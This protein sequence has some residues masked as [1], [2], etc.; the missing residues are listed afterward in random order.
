MQDDKTLIEGAEMLKY[1]VET[2]TLKT[3]T[4]EKTA[5]M[6]LRESEI[7]LAMLARDGFKI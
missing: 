6:G 1:F 3:Y 7:A 4:L 5:K 2:G